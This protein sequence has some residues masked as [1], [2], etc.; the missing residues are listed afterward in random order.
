MKLTTLAILVFGLYA[1][2]V[3]ALGS[4]T[5]PI[6][7]GV[8]GNSTLGPDGAGSL[9]VEQ[10]LSGD[11]NKSAYDRSREQRADPEGYANALWDTSKPFDANAATA[12]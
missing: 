4:A 3:A 12:M 7:T 11:C 2:T 5:D 8:K 1:G 6:D 9:A 10:C